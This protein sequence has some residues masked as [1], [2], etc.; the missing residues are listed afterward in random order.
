M[1]RTRTGALAL[2]DRSGKTVDSSRYAGDTQPPG[3]YLRGRP[4]DTEHDTRDPSAKD[5]TIVVHVDTVSVGVAR[6]DVTGAWMLYERP[7]WARWLQALGSIPGA[8]LVLWDRPDLLASGLAQS[9]LA[10]RTESGLGPLKK[11]VF[12]VKNDAVVRGPEPVLTAAGAVAA[13]AAAGVGTTPGATGP[14]MGGAVAGYEGAVITE[15]SEEGR[16]RQLYEHDDG[17]TGYGPAASDAAADAATI[18]AAFRSGRRT[19]PSVDASS[20]LSYL[21]PPEV[22]DA[23][24]YRA[25][26][27]ARDTGLAVYDDLADL[28]EEWRG[29]MQHWWSLQP[30]VPI[31]HDVTLTRRR[32]GMSPQVGYGPDADRE[33]ALAA[34]PDPARA[35]PFFAAASDADWGSFYDVLEYKDRP[36]LYCP[37]D[38]ARLDAEH[39]RRVDGHLARDVRSLRRDMRRVVVI[40]RDPKQRALFPEN[41]LRTFQD[42]AVPPHVVLTALPL[43]PAPPAAAAAD[44]AEFRSLALLL[45]GLQSMRV[46]DVKE[47]VLGW[48]LAE[49]NVTAGLGPLYSDA[50]GG[51]RNPVSGEVQMDR[52]RSALLASSYDQRLNHSVLGLAPSP[53]SLLPASQAAARA[54]SEATGVPPPPPPNAYQRRAAAHLSAARAALAERAAPYIDAARSTMAALSAVGAAEDA[55]ADARGAGGAAEVTTATADSSAWGAWLPSWL[56]GGGVNAAAEADAA[57]AAAT[58]AAALAAVDAATAAAAATA[59]AFPRAAA[60]LPHGRPAGPE[61]AA[62]EAAALATLGPFAG[63]VAAIAAQARTAAAEEAAI[64]GSASSSAAAAIGSALAVSPSADAAA[65]SVRGQRYGYTAALSTVA[66]AGAAVRAAELSQ[67]LAAADRA[68][69]RG[70][71]SQAAWEARVQAIEAEQEAVAMGAASEREFREMGAPLLSDRPRYY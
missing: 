65:A 63:R 1:L 23:A 38:A 14:G 29:D 10:Q 59:T 27:L 43:R 12:E 16:I 26:L 53:A 3:Q 34:V 54:V 55:R 17:S 57:A 46:P 68:H 60:Q 42:S 45:S 58:T 32:T 22:E 4:T 11:E 15:S 33:R 40:D 6:D 37:P 41:T 24:A 13:A 67:A 48:N 20:I 62:A 18:A 7:G 19:A 50:V 64:D 21:S 47:P 66:A 25:A 39:Y 35:G 69:E 2:P 9:D 5:L 31:V 49:Q 44:A 28:E 61:E 51:R 8:E 56:G 52:L 30:R 70:A 71:L 36:E